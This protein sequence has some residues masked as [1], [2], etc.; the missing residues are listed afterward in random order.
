[1]A[2]RNSS[3]KKDSAHI[4]GYLTGALAVDHFELNKLTEPKD[5]R[6]IAVAGGINAAVQKAG[7]IL[8]SRPNGENDLIS[9]NGFTDMIHAAARQSLV[10][11]PIYYTGDRP[12]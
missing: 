6:H 10:D 9:L 7:G 8:K 4:D 11:D 5:G 2:G 3:S 12:R 1:M